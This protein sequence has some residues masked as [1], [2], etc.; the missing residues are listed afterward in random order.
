MSYRN[1]AGRARPSRIQLYWVAIRNE[2]REGTFRL[3]ALGQPSVGVP[4]NN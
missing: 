3:L 1:M 4:Q 2:V